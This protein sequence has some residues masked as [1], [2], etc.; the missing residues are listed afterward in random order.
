MM[1][2]NSSISKQQGNIGTRL[3]LPDVDSRI[4]TSHKFSNF[5]KTSHEKKIGFKYLSCQFL[6]KKLMVVCS[7]TKKNISSCIRSG[8][9]GEA[10][11]SAVCV[12]DTEDVVN[13]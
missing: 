3:S 6:R 11:Q 10:K 7:A 8:S 12:S 13:R 1:S 5:L 9:C 2:C 4:V